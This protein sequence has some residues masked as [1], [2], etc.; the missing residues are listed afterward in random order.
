MKRV[1]LKQGVM[2]ALSAV[3]ILLMVSCAG[4]KLTSMWVS[5]D[6]R[7]GAFER[8][9]VVALS[10]D[11]DKRKAFESD[12]VTGL[13]EKGV[14]G[15]AAAEAMAPNRELTREAVKEA[16]GRSAADSILVV[17]LVR[18]EEKSVYV[19]AT[20]HAIPGAFDSRFDSRFPLVYQYGRE[21]GS[22]QKQRYVYFDNSFYEAKTG[23][24]V[25]SAKSE[26]FEPLSEKQLAESLCEAVFKSLRENKLVR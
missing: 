25:W 4:T 22:Q 8:I 20:T 17:Q 10:E 13:K 14:A 6:Y 1:D 3:G 7:G 23:Q 18:V 11:Y 26:I 12:F 16:A 19:P 24:L 5:P 2:R 9:L 15:L 21:S